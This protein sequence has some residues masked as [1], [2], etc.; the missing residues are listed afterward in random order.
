VARRSTERDNCIRVGVWYT[1]G[2]FGLG[3]KG[4]ERKGKGGREEK[5]NAEAQR[6]LRC[7]EQNR[8]RTEQ[9]RNRAE[10][11]RRNAETQRA[12]RKTKEK[13]T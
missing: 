4:T 8:N 11:R 10:Q 5:E 3:E 1:T 2:R 7:A 12:Q 13:E 9:S 6:T